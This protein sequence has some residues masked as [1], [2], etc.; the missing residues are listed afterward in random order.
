MY[1]RYL[2]IRWGVELSKMVVLVGESGDSDYEGLLGGVHRTVILKGSFN[3]P[4]SSL[5]KKR[6]YPLQDVVASD[7]AK[8]VQSDGCGATDI[9]TALQKFGILKD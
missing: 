9:K 8:F 4:P 3:K 5:H 6:S 1:Y 2:Y 7:N